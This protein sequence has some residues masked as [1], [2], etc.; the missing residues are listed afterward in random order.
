MARVALF[1]RTASAIKAFLQPPPYATSPP[2]TEPL[3][4]ATGLDAARWR[5]RNSVKPTPMA[6]PDDL[7][8]R[9]GL[10]VYAQMRR[11]DQVKAVLKLRKQA[12]LSTGWDVLPAELNAGSR[13][14]TDPA[15]VAEFVKHNLEEELQDG[16]E[17]ALQEALT[18]LDFGFS[19][20]EILYRPLVTGRWRGKVGLDDLAYRAPGDYVFEA[21]LHG[22]LGS[23]GV[24]QA[25]RKLPADRF[26]LWSYGKEFDNW[27]GQSE[28]RAAYNWWWLKDNVQR[29]WGIFLDRYSVPLAVGKLPQDVLN[30]AVVDDFKTVLQNLQADTSIIMPSGFDLGFPAATTAQGSQIFDAAIARCDQGIAKAIL[31][32]SLLGVSE[33]GDVGSYSQARKQFDVFILVVESDQRMLAK[34]VIGAQLVRRLVD[35]NFCVEEYPTFEFLPFTES[36]KGELLTQFLQALSASAVGARPEDEAHIR[37]VTEFPEVPEE[38]LQAE[39]AERKDAA[40]AQ[41]E[42][43]AGGGLAGLMGAQPPAGELPA[44]GQEVAVPVGE[45]EDPLVQ[46]VADALAAKGHKVYKDIVRADIADTVARLREEQPDAA[47]PELLDAAIMELEGGDGEDP[48]AQDPGPDGVDDAELDRLIEEALGGGDGEPGAE[49]EGLTDEELDALI[50]EALAQGSPDETRAAVEQEHP[51]WTPEQVDAELAKQKADVIQS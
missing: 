12:V 16:F 11:D 22:R 50:A 18:A 8:G 17:G 10:K 4:I 35:L 34:R 5:F 30:Q 44:P 42:A 49:A 45:G 19:A 2:L 36:N 28:L 37:T 46:Q 26:L 43:G 7:V 3:T 51:D 23:W 32:P 15:E 29:W 27:Y 48:G 38:T 14:G 21:D 41:A 6:N 33:Q 24:V 1:S 40:A 25:G 13:S 20:G 39:A 31:V 9:K 47:D